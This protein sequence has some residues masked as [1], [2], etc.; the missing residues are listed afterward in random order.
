MEQG[1]SDPQYCRKRL[2]PGHFLE[3]E[4]AV[5][6]WHRE[7][8]AVG[9]SV[10]GCDLKDASVRLAAQMK[11]SDFHA[12]DG[13]LFRF[14]Q[15]HGM[16]HGEA[17]SARQDAV[18]PFREELNRIINSEGLL[19]SQV[20]NF[21]ETALFWRALPTSTQVFGRTTQAKG[22]KL[23]KSRISVLVG[24]NADGSH[25]LPPVVCGKSA[26]PRAIKDCMAT[27]P[28]PYHS[29]GKC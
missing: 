22:R 29:S 12:S 17:G 21:D 5:L 16:F 4:K 27:L 28:I 15:R 24:A 10:R 9:I 6:K 25:R 1:V 8:E 3:L 7:Q 2:T 20:Y 26:R 18:G 11:I 23:D 14:R 19:L 13:W